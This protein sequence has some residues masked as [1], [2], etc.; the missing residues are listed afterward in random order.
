MALRMMGNSASHRLM[1][2]IGLLSI[3]GLTLAVAVLLTVLSVM[4]G[5]ER[6]LRERVLGVMPHGTVYS[7]TGYPGAG[8]QAVRK[9]VLAHPDITGVAP[10][11]EGKG[12]LMANG[13]L[14]GVSFRGID[15][16]LEPDV[17]ILPQFMATGAFD[18]L[19]DDRFGTILGAETAE[20]LG[21]GIGEK[22]TLVL[23]EA[24]LTLA[25]AVLTTR[26]L[27]V[28]GVFQVGADADKE[29][30]L[31]DLK[32]AMKLKRQKHIDG[33]VV[34]TGDLFEVPRVLHEISL[35]NP[36]LV[37]VSW[38][39]RNGSLYDAIGTQKATMFLLL[40]I[41]VAVAAFNVVS[42]LVMTVDDN[43]SGIAILRTMGASP[44]DIRSVFLLHGLFVGLSGL[45]L[46]LVLGILLTISLSP[47][48]AMVSDI[49][50]LSLMKEYFIRYLPT[51]ILLT[52]IALIFTVTVFICLIATLYPAS[53]AAGANPVEA[54]QHEF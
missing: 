33:L 22:V 4:N 53:R 47:L 5:F 30:I 15:T 41:L 54:L 10:L 19:S 28:S 17:S 49:F 32:D 40:M 39:R 45:V 34:R 13:E 26:Q 9:A 38:M 46:G 24:R 3:S 50:G 6:E 23:P 7:R 37:G 8:W 12:M 2:F 1:S 27:T 21:V 14:L 31:L 44:R 42:N 11:I 36:D 20:T 18:T 35:S 16:D 52:D 48:Y 51:E 43:R 29:V 25:G